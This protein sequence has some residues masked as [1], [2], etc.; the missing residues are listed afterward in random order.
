LRMWLEPISGNFRWAFEPLGSKKN[1]WQ[2]ASS[3]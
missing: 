3:I 2:A 1:T